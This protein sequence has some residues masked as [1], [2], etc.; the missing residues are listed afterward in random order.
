VKF[1]DRNA[2]LLSEPALW[3][4]IAGKGGTAVG[5]FIDK[6]PF[7]AN[8]LVGLVVAYLPLLIYC[9]LQRPRRTYLLAA[10]LGGAG[11]FLLAMLPNGIR[12]ARTPH[13]EWYGAVVVGTIVRAWIAA[14]VGSYATVA[15]VAYRLKHRH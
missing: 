3:R 13:D 9:A 6:Y 5:E 11:F 15:V 1:Q 10:L 4:D 14:I 12:L 8:L 7:V 2:F